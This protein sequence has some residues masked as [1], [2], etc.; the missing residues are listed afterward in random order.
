MSKFTNLMERQVMRQ[1]VFFAALTGSHLYGFAT[2]QSDMDIR[3]AHAIPLVKYVGLQVGDQNIKQVGY[4]FETATSFDIQSA[5][6]SAY[7]NRILKRNMHIMEEIYAPDVYVPE[8]MKAFF[9]ELRSIAKNYITVNHSAHY[10]GMAKQLYSRARE[11]GSLS[12]KVAL[13]VFRNYFSGIHLMRSKHLECNLIALLDEFPD[14]IPVVKEIYNSRID[15]P[16]GEVRPGDKNHIM[17][18]FQQ[19]DA[20]LVAARDASSLP[21]KAPSAEPLNNLLV[22]IRLSSMLKGVYING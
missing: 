1:P 13:H 10:L 4:D 7:F 21:E 12:Y 9:E 15:V 14:W 8:D 18:L 5:D 17:D 19:L 22:R 16:D 2:S 11:E 20:Q 3:G 6:V